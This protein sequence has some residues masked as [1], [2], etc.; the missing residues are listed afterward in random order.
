MNDLNNKVEFI[1]Q[2]PVHPKIRLK[3]ISK[4]TEAASLILDLRNRLPN[5]KLLKQPRNKFAAKEAQIA[6]NNVSRLM[7]GE[8]DFSLKNVLN[9]TLVFDTSKINE[10]VITDKII[11]LINDPLNDE[12]YIDHPSGI[13]S[14]TLKREDER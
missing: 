4:K 5:D 7:R 1:K 9:K 13:N 2:V 8:F 6:G 10:E 12:Y 3:K 14:F 11:E